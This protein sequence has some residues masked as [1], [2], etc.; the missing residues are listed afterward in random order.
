MT[1]FLTQLRSLGWAV[2]EA[3]FLL[4]VLCVLLNIILGNES[5]SFISGVAQNA[6]EFLQRLPPGIFLGIVLI[7]VIYS[8][9]KS[10]LQR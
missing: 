1:N 4:I 6:T 10:R 3:A 8:L 7:A 9:V 2:V 5:G